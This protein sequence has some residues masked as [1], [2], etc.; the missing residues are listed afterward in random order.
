MMQPEELLDFDR[1]PMSGCMYFLYQTLAMLAVI[2]LVLLP[3]ISRQH[4]TPG[5]IE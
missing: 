4:D 1:E 5:G 2:V 3:F